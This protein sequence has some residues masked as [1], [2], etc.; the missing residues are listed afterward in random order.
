MRRMGTATEEELSGFDKLLQ[1]ALEHPQ[2]VP[3]L[4]NA[5]PEMLEFVNQS[6]ETVLHWLAVEN[7]VDGIRL[8]HGLGAK[9]PEFALIHALQAGHTETVDLLL[10]LGAEFTRL[11]P[12]DEIQNPIWQLP[13]QKQQELALCLTVHGYEA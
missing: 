7:H 13:V 9:I 12:I 6:A 5:Q 1:A 8:L 2:T 3:M 11:D 10:T 4:V